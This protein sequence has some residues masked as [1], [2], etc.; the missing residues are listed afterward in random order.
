MKGNKAQKTKRSR[1]PKSERRTDVTSKAIMR[2]F[3]ASFYDLLISVKYMS[4]R[5]AFKYNR[6][7]VVSF[8]KETFEQLFRRPN[9]D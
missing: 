5:D 9:E 3:R 1:I 4:K 2:M 6:E 7:K 8:I